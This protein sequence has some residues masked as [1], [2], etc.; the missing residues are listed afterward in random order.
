VGRTA[1]VRFLLLFTR[2]SVV[3]LFSLFSVR[4]TAQLVGSRT[5]EPTNTMPLQDRDLVVGAGR[6]QYASFT[7]TDLDAIAPWLDIPKKIDGPG[8]GNE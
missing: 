5:K 8:L 3:Y 7:W 4:I 1:N 6:S 2:L